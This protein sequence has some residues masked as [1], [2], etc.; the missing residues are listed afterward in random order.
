M[1]FQQLDNCPRCGK[2]FVRTKSICPDCFKKQEE[3]FSKVADFLQ[4]NPGCN[5]QE[6][7][8]QTNVSIAQIRQFILA[9]RIVLSDF[10]NLE[11]ACES[12]GAMIRKGRICSECSNTIT[13]LAVEF[14][15]R[16][17]TTGQELKKT[18]AYRSHLHFE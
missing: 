4:R 17:K 9:E 6:L 13:Q 12:C 5:I 15:Q 3:E 14:K 1:G 7:S 10:I 18:T 16:E 11:Y 2:L 8:D